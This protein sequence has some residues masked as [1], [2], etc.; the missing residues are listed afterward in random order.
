MCVVRLRP[1]EENVVDDGELFFKKRDALLT[2][3]EMII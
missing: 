3:Q 2:T 1:S